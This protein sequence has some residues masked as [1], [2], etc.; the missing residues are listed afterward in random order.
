MP[1]NLLGTLPTTL[2]GSWLWVPD[3][4][5]GKCAKKVKTVGASYIVFESAS[6]NDKGGPLDGNPGYTG[7]EIWFRGAAIVE[8][9]SLPELIFSLLVSTGT[10]NNGPHDTLPGYL[11]F[12]LPAELVDATIYP[13]LYETRILG[14]LD[15]VELDAE[16][17]ALGFFVTFADGRFTVKPADIPEAYNTTETY[18]E[19]E[20]VKAEELTA[21]WAKIAPIRTITF[22]AGED[23]SL[24]ASTGAYSPATPNGGRAE[25]VTHLL[26]DVPAPGHIANILRIYRWASSGSAALRVV[27]P[28]TEAPNVGE[29]VRLESSILAASGAYGG[30]VAGFVTET[31][32]TG[33]FVLHVGPVDPGRYLAPALV[34]VS[35]ASGVLT[36]TGGALQFFAFPSDTGYVMIRLADGLTADVGS[37]SAIDDKHVQLSIAP[38][39][40]DGYIFSVRQYG[41]IDSVS[42]KNACA[43]CDLSGVRWRKQ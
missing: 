2:A 40:V 17:Q 9:D 27:V 33:E 13:T 34:P 3:G 35:Y 41:D 1:V 42:L 14:D 6:Y 8:F 30:A 38:P 11:G 23:F 37:C 39:S 36:V 21:R 19:G 15:Q 28:P 12:G 5:D 26:R 22:K 43:F 16:L 7:H 25:V 31:T 4:I 20:V 32:I 24:I 10:G 18:T 29:V